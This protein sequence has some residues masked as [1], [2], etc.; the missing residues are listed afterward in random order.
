MEVIQDLKN[1]LCELKAP[2][3]WESVAVKIEHLFSGGLKH[4]RNPLFI[5]DE[6]I[7]EEVMTDEE[8]DKA[9]HLPYRE[10]CGMC[11]YPASC[12]KLEM[13]YAISV[14]GRHRGK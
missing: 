14:C 5:N 7:M 12:S 11:S 1:S 9:K 3:Y 13:C 2:K 6:K 8:H 4:Y 10:L